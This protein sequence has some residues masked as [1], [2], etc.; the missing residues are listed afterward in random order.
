MVTYNT[1]SNNDHPKYM[2]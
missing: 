1:T 2:H